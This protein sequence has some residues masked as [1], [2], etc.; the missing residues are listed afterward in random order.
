MDLVTSDCAAAAVFAL[1]T[2]TK[3][4]GRAF[5]LVPL[6]PV[7]LRDFVGLLP[8]PLPMVAGNFKFLEPVL[9]LHD[10]KGG[11]V[12]PSNPGGIPRSTMAMLTTW[13][14]LSQINRRK[15][16]PLTRPHFK[17]RVCLSARKRIPNGELV[18]AFGKQ[19]N[20]T[21]AGPLQLERVAPPFDLFRTCGAQR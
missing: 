21:I 20:F 13:V 16:E 15:F 4:L 10:I 5:H 9:L 12:P 14:M 18:P 11:H 3:S 19:R 1:S 7:S 8:T 17:P 6:K 2:R